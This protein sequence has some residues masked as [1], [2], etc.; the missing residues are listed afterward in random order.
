MCTSVNEALDHLDR[1][2][3]Q[4]L[5]L[6]F[7]DVAG[8]PIRGIKRWS[9]KLPEVCTLLPKRLSGNQHHDQWYQDHDPISTLQK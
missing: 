9:V 5:L 6:S 7:P 2:M 3:H 4:A 1:W 8:C